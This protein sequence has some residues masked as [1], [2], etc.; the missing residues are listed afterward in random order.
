MSWIKKTLSVLL[1]GFPGDFGNRGPP[2]PDGNPVS[3]YYVLINIVKYV[4]LNIN[5][6][7]KQKGDLCM[8]SKVLK[9]AGKFCTVTFI[10]KVQG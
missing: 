5:S 9:S 10:W 8:K 6:S 2:G 1:Q 7:P 4:T 3:I